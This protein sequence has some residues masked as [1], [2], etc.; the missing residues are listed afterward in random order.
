[1]EI[2]IEIFLDKNSVKSTYI[3]INHMYPKLI[4]LYSPQSEKT[5]KNLSHLFG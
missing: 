2:E 3:L 5:K 1:M 4:F